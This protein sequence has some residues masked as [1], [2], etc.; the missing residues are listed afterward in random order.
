[1]SML[2]SI[3][4]CS[5]SGQML[6]STDI[7]GGSKSFLALSGLM[8]VFQVN[9]KRCFGQDSTL[10]Y[11]KLNNVAMTIAYNETSG[12]QVILIHHANYYRSLAKCIAQEILQS[13]SEHFGNN[14]DQ[15]QFKRFNALL[16]PAI[17]SASFSL[18][19]SLLDE[20]NGAIIYAVIFCEGDSLYAYPTNANLI[21]VAANLQQLQFS[22]QETARLADDDPYELVTDS[23]QVITHIV[24]FGTTTIVL[25]VKKE[26]HTPE[27]VAAV[28]S[29]IEML[30]LCFRTAEGLMG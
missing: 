11:L 29:T 25:Q 9:T 22:L 15:S 26:R 5:K 24:L 28:K 16:G 6:F 2:H 1:M 30:D 20:T 7:E 18:L 21:S 13:F 14:S 3:C 10:N 12:V 8:A 27:V 17:Q 23:G 4:I 19:R